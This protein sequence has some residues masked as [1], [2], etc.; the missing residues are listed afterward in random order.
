METYRFAAQ[1]A[2]RLTGETVP[3][4]AAKGGEGRTELYDAATSSVIGAITP[5]NF[6]MNLVAHKVGPAL[7]AGNTIV[8]ETCGADASVFLLHR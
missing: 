3:M 7:A 8:L 1:E 4:D 6:P 2:K 5:F